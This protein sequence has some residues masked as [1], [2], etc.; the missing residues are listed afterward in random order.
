MVS[1]QPKLKG[2]S[3]WPFNACSEV[4][5][6]CLSHMNIRE[7]LPENFTTQCF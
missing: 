4:A 5:T 3:I 2:A 7:V 1:L 6:G